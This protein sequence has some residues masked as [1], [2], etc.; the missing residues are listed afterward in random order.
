M[1][2]ADFAPPI[3]KIILIILAAAIIFPAVSLPWSLI[4][5]ASDILRIQSIDQK[6]KK[7]EYKEAFLSLF[8][9]RNGRSRPFH[10]IGYWVNYKLFGLNSRLHH[11]ARSGLFVC[12][13]FLL[14]QFTLE[15]SAS[16]LA[17]FCAG[18][19]YFF[20]LTA[21]ESYYRLGPQEPMLV[22][23]II[24]SLLFLIRA[25]K[26]KQS[27]K[28][29]QTDFIVSILV[30]AIAYFVKEISLVLI[31]ISLFIFI[32]F[33][34]SGT[35]G[36][37]RLFMFYFLVNCFWGIAA[38]LLTFLFV[39]SGSR[40]GYA[41]A[42]VVDVGK[43]FNNL[44][45]YFNLLYYTYHLLF[46]LAGLGF[47]T[48]FIFVACK[49]KSLAFE[50]KW[51]LIL[52][53]CF[54]GFLLI[55]SPWGYVMWRYLLPCIL[56][57]S[58]FLGIEINRAVDFLNNLSSR[59]KEIIGKSVLAVFFIQY[60]FLNSISVFSTIQ[61]YLTS[62]AIN[63][64]MVSYL[65]NNVPSSGKV[66]MNLNCVEPNEWYAETKMHL[67]LFHK[68]EDIT[69]QC[70]MPGPGEAFIPGN[71]VLTWSEQG[72]LPEEVI[73]SKLNVALEKKA[74]ISTNYTFLTKEK[75]LY[76]KVFEVN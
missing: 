16:K 49:R 13:I 24:C 36:D 55:N 32:L 39:S 59:K 21:V 1:T 47:L 28:A 25:Q 17:A 18:V 11:L 31:P 27:G 37:K 54:F 75:E 57:L 69:V 44:L 2:K 20:S 63:A 8:E 64:K 3:V 45:N 15:V 34:F 61:G 68:R 74:T 42:Y 48:Y 14:F 26:A 73:A 10:W 19:F 50:V 12:T 22:L 6:I 62:E 67:S 43:M 46:P 76:W 7:S 51:E 65:A 4:D 60:L 29:W 9:P 40:Q 70:L 66:Y 72:F 38:R 33:Y 56:T 5:D 71:L 58:I 30:L 53:V 52:L 35:N 41:S 23:G